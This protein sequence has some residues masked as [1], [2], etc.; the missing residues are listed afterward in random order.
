MPTRYLEILAVQ[1]PFS[2][3]VDG[4]G[5]TQFSCNFEAT[6]AAPI[7]DLK[8]EVLRLITDAGLG[9]RWT[10]TTGDLFVGRHTIL[11]KGDGPYVV[12]VPTA[13]FAPL[14]THNGDRYERPGVQIIVTAQ[15]YSDAETR[16]LAIYRALDGVRNTEVTGLAP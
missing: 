10:G 5:R 14:E 3:G 4:N 12:V 6:A 8:N 9:T 1:H 2:I 15:V 11:P 16:A 7:A 13:G